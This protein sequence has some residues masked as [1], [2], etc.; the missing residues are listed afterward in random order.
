MLWKTKQ[1]ILTYETVTSLILLPSC[2][3]S[4]AGSIGI[5]QF[6]KHFERSAYSEQQSR[7]RQRDERK[8]TVWYEAEADGFGRSR[9]VTF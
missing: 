4:L 7:T 2:Y 1:E 8:P 5:M 3:S 9:D 6:T